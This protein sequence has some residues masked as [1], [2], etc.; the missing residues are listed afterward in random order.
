M[1]WSFSRREELNGFQFELQILQKGSEMLCRSFVLA[2]SKKKKVPSSF[3]PWFLNELFNPQKTICKAFIKK[4]RSDKFP[5]LP[6][7]L[8]SPLFP[9]ERFLC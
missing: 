4:N 9:V 6:L 2:L 5:H 8:E 7:S 3:A 1:Y